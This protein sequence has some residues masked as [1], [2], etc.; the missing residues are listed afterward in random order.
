M[1][2]AFG[3]AKSGIGIAGIGT[4]KPELIMRVS[5]EHLFLRSLLRNERSPLLVSRT[6]RHVWYHS[7]LWIGGV[8][9]H[10]WLTFVPLNSLHVNDIPMLSLQ[11]TPQM[12]ILSP[13]GSF[14]LVQASLVASLVLLRAT[15]S[16]SSATQYVVLVLVRLSSSH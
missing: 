6:G 16:A 7:S 12:I 4:F 14:T 9:T 15:Q 2:A 10:L 1:G 8:G 13:P 11:Y 3:T 5:P